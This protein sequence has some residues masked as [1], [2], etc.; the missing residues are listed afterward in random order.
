VRGLKAP[1]RRH[2]V[3]DD[4]DRRELSELQFRVGS[5]LLR[6][7]FVDRDVQQFRCQA[8]RLAG[9]P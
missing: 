2:P 3:I 5:G 1:Q 9:Y 4:P 7:V 8:S 6:D